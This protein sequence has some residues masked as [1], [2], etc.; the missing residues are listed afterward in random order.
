MDLKTG[1]AFTFMVSV[2]AVQQELSKLQAH[3]VQV[4]QLVFA[5][6]SAMEHVLS[7][8][9]RCRAEHALE[10]AQPELSST[11]SQQSNSK[12]SKPSM[13]N[14]KKFIVTWA[15]PSSSATT[16]DDIVYAFD[17]QSAKHAYQLEHPL[18]LVVCCAEATA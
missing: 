13:S 11:G 9:Y 3:G 4:P 8:D 18:R 5:E 17:R 10:P 2:H 16:F 6:L 12:R 14:I 7:R 1:D 15:M